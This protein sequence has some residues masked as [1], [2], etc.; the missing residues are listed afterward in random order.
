MDL[1]F[2]WLPSQLLLIVDDRDV[3]RWCLRD[4]PGNGAKR[5]AQILERR[6]HSVGQKHAEGMLRSR[7]A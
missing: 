2:C 1:A 4:I 5:V 6:I 7:S 3:M